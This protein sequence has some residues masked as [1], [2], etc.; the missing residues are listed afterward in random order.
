MKILH[1]LSDSNIGG[2]GIL[3]LNCLAHFDRSKFDIKV[4]LPRDAELCE[5]V[6]SLGYEVIS[7]KYGK[8][9]S[10]EKAATK[11]L[12]E[13]FKSEKP[14]I[15]HTHSS[16][17]AR[18]AAKKCKV[19]LIFQTHHCAVMPPKYKTFFPFKQLLGALNNHYSDRIIATAE[20]ASRILQIQG[21]KKEKISVIINGTEPM[22]KVTDSEKNALREELGIS[23]D[24]FVFTIAARLEEVKDHRTFIEAAAEGARVH[25]DMRFLIAGK[26]SLEESLKSLAKDLSVDDKII[27]TGFCRDVAPYMNITDINVNCSISET[28]CLAISEGMS[29]SLPTI[30]SDC[31]GNLAMIKDGIN[32]LTFERGNAEMLAT[33]MVTLYENEALRRKMS[34]NALKLFNEK[35]TAS[36]MTNELQKL[37]ITEYSKKCKTKG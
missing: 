13:I 12:L 34:E 26:G 17:S 14:D 10:Y 7:M 11:E 36:V 6:E 19:P 4:V 9:A 32:G 31:E 3:L 33:A 25:P 23:K 1:V 16:F 21:T 35:F 24:D 18:I 5:R 22:R 2:A 37:Y 20:I 30:A 8:D 28:S 15:V 29:L 27:F